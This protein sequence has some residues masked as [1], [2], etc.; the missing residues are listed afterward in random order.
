MNKGDC[1]R[2]VGWTDLDYAPA[3]EMTCM[4]VELSRARDTL[5]VV[6]AWA[7]LYADNERC[8]GRCMCGVTEQAVCEAR[9]ATRQDAAREVLAHL[10]R[11]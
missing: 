11:G 10:G 7:N 4:A 9:H 1:L 6:R 3:P 8:C 5:G 2:Y